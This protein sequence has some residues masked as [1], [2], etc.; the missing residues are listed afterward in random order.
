LVEGVERELLEF[1]F[2]VDGVDNRIFVVE[3]LLRFKSVIEVIVVGGLSVVIWVD[4][5]ESFVERLFVGCINCILDVLNLVSEPV[6]VDINANS[7][8]VFVNEV[9]GVV[10]EAV[11]VDCFPGGIDDAPEVNIEERKATYKVKKI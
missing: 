2:D 8:D 5:E 10:D 11:K 6:S 1:V 7:V 3:G 9:A 4:E